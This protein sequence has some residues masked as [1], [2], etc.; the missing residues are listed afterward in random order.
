[1]EHRNSFFAGYECALVD[2][3]CNHRTSIMYDDSNTE[4]AELKVI[5]DF[6]VVWVGN[7]YPKDYDSKVK[8]LNRYI[9]DMMVVGIEANKKNNRQ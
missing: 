7:A 5:R 3:I 4:Y 8:L 2:C 6:E 1:M 9:K